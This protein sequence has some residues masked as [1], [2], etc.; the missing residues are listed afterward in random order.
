MYDS[1]MTIPFGLLAEGTCHFH[2]IISLIFAHCR[3]SVSMQTALVEA[4]HLCNS[5]TNMMPDYKLTKMEIQEGYFKVFKSFHGYILF[6]LLFEF[7]AAILP[8][9]YLCGTTSV[10]AG[11]SVTSM[12]YLTLLA[13]VT[14][15]D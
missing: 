11:K 8:R 12:F 13:C 2:F 3:A 15:S 6:M 4:V 10:I 7:P 5:K 1:K 9:T 14:W